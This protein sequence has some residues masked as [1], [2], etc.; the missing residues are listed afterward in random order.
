MREVT[1]G[2]TATVLVL[3]TAGL[4]GVSVAIHIA[5]VLKRAL[6]FRTFIIAM[7]LLVYVASGVVHVSRLGGTNRGYVDLLGVSNVDTL[8]LPTWATV[9]GLAALC[10]GTLRSLRMDLE[11]VQPSRVLARMPKRGL[12]WAGLILL[13]PTLFALT[14]M[15]S[16]AATS[17]SDRIISLE[18]GMARYGFLSQ[19]FTW[20]ISFLALWLAASKWGRSSWRVATLLLGSIAA[21]VLSLSWTGGR[22]IALMMCLPLILTFWPLLGRLKVWLACALADRAHCQLFAN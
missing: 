8:S 13:P 12:F 15:N 1:P 17:V 2:Q 9:L 10:A 18:G 19:W 20:A 14:Q 21:I 11:P 7:Y 4:L 3:I 16:F 22:A 6:N 5:V